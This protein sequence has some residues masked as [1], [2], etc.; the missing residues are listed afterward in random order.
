MNEKLN[1]IFNIKQP[2]TIGEIIETSKT[3]K[4]TENQEQ[5]F[6]VD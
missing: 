6:S 4:K 1:E 5:D 3:I 2:E